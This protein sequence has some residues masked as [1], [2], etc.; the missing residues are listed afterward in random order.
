MRTAGRESA[1][2]PCRTA[3]RSWSVGVRGWRASSHS[4]P[5]SPLNTL[6]TRLDQARSFLALRIGCALSGRTSGLTAYICRGGLS[7]RRSSLE[8]LRAWCP[9]SLVRIGCKGARRARRGRADAIRRSGWPASSVSGEPR[10]LVR[11]GPIPQLGSSRQRFVC[12]TAPAPLTCAAQ[13]IGSA[14]HARTMPTLSLHTLRACLAIVECSSPSTVARSS[15]SPSS[16]LSE[17]S[18]RQA[19]IVRGRRPSSAARRL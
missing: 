15:G 18:L 10:V 12:S 5:L 6:P 9:R 8:R 7:L 14:E 1:A 11:P 3:S 2:R 4:S 13:S 16:R 19:R 17:R